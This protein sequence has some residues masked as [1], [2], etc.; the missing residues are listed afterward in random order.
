[1]AVGTGSG[2]ALRVRLNRGRRIRR[3]QDATGTTKRGDTEP[4]G[5]SNPPS[6]RLR[7][8]SHLPRPMANAGLPFGE[9]TVLPVGICD[10]VY[11]ALPQPALQGRVPFRM[12][13]DQQPGGRL[14]TQRQTNVLKRSVGIM[15]LIV[16]GSMVFTLCSA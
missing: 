16:G 10:L 3:Q 9:M 6:V 14:G 11:N 15:D 12:F 5:S 13:A 2:L 7:G 4:H 1:V 8:K